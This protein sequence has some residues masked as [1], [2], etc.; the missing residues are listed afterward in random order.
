MRWK[1]ERSDTSK[2]LLRIEKDAIYRLMERMDKADSINSI[3]PV[4][5][6]ISGFLGNKLLHD[7]LSLDQL[8][9]LMALYERMANLYT[10][11]AAL[12]VDTNPRIEA[13]RTMKLDLCYKFMQ[14]LCDKG[15][16]LKI[17]HSFFSNQSTNIAAS[18]AIELI[19]QSIKTLNDQYDKKEITFDEFKQGALACLSED[20]PEVKCLN[21]HRGIKQILTNL[22]TA[23][24]LLGIGYAIVAA[25]KGSW[26]VCPVDT[27]SGEAVEQLKRSIGKLI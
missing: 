18:N 17:R 26:T 20:K 2:E 25:C 14:A 21:Q 3:G 16:E 12:L 27:D 1:F 5:E 10:K 22:L 23:I 9:E 19:L 11:K 8:R 24:G 15:D 13:V 7:S 6:E 4:A